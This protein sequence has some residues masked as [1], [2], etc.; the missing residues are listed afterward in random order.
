MIPVFR[1]GYVTFFSKDVEAMIDYYTTVL[2]C[3]LIERGE[4]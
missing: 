3:T 1:L 2:G 4:D